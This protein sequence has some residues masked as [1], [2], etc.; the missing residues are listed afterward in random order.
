MA[1][2]IKNVDSC[3]EIPERTSDGLSILAYVN[4]SFTPGGEWT[5]YIAAS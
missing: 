1:R 3:P 5:K 2:N 4:S